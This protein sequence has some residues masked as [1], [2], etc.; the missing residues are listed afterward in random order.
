MFPFF[1]WQL[2]EMSE[3][4]PAGACDVKNGCLMG[5]LPPEIGRENQMRYDPGSIQYPQASAS[6]ASA[7]F[8]GLP[9]Q[10]HHANGYNETV[11][12]PQ[13]DRGEHLNNFREFS[14]VQQS[15]IGGTIGYRHRPDDHE[16]K[17]RQVPDKSKQLE[18]EKFRFPQ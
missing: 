16:Q 13:E 4:L 7:R 9:P 12:V 6:V 11:I 2:K 15:A 14:S 8:G 10:A 17:E 18:H 3:R 5:A 1:F